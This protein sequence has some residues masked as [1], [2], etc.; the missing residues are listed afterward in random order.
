MKLKKLSDLFAYFA[1][2]GIHHLLASGG[3][4]QCCHAFQITGGGTGTDSATFASL[5]MGGQKVPDMADATYVVVLGETIT[6]A[7]PYVDETS[8]A[9]TGF[10]IKGLNAAEVANVVV[11]GRA[12]DMRVEA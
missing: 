12:A 4:Q 8:K 11:I 6:S 3:P 9:T 5:T 7:D 2:R 1:K 10:D